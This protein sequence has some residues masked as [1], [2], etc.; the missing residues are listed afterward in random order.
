MSVPSWCRHLC[1]ASF[2]V[3]S[4]FHQSLRICRSISSRYHLTPIQVWRGNAHP[5]LCPISFPSR[6]LR[7]TSHIHP[8][9]ISP[10]CRSWCSYL[11]LIHVTSQPHPVPPKLH[12]NSIQ[13]PS[14]IS[15]TYSTFYVCVSRISRS[16]INCIQVTSL[17]S[18]FH[19]C[20]F[21][22]PSR[23]LD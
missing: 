18:K 14:Q 15:Q 6:S 9:R 7:C 11:T 17:L 1:L 8:G 2:Q 3:S 20:P 22:P 16:C 12:L 19:P 13:A 5:N 23:F 10:Q 4:L 21:W